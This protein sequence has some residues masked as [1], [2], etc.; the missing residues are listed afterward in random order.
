MRIRVVTAR[1]WSHAAASGTESHPE[2]VADTEGV[3]TFWST[4]REIGMPAAWAMSLTARHSE[5]VAEMQRFLR[6]FP[7]LRLSITI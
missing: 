5:S 3:S 4:K 6:G 2:S 1:S 7:G